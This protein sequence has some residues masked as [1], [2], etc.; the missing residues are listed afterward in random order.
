VKL[1]IL[2]L[3]SSLLIPAA[4]KATPE[5]PIAKVQ[6]EPKAA[7]AGL[8]KRVFLTGA[9]LLAA[10][11][12]ADLI[13]TRQCLDRG[14]CHELDPLYG[15]R[16]PSAERQAGLGIVYYTTRVALFYFTERNQNRFVRWA[17]RTMMVGFTVGHAVEAEK[18][19]TVRPN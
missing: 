15:A 2:I 11:Q 3:A 1:G 4:A 17:G 5:A 6:S 18:G 13:T 16:Y 14:A 9:T 19:A 8:D 7:A 12:A 10:A